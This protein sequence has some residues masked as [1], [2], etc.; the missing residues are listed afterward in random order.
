LKSALADTEIVWQK[1]PEGVT[2]NSFYLL[3]GRVKSRKRRDAL[4][5]ELK[6]AGVPCTPFYP[7]TLY[8]NEVYR[9]QPCRVMPCPIAEQC[10]NDA[11][12]LPHRVLLAHD[13]VIANIAQIMRQS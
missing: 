5:G 8:E 3:T 13:D 1:E 6:N 4:C 12:W 2:Q 7:H 9:K 11:F 10:V